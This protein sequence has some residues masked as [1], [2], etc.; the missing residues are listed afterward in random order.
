MENDK[1]RLFYTNLKEYEF[2]AELVDFPSLY[3]NTRTGQSW[4]YPE[5]KGYHSR[6]YWADIKADK[7][8]FRVINASE[9]DIYLGLFNPAGYLNN[10]I[11][12]LDP[13]GQL[14]MTNR[15]GNK[16]PFNGK[17]LFEFGID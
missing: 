8:G 13:Q 15:W 4:D 10:D 14:N 16:I 17:L 2:Y 12:Q 3:N 9:Q 1:N 6:L 5:F 7:R 11:E